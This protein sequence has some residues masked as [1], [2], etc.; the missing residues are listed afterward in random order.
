V[1]LAAEEA[2]PAHGEDVL[3]IDF[4]RGGDAQAAH[5]AAV[6]VE[7]HVGMRGVHRAVGIEHVEMRRHHLQLVGRGL[8]HAVAALFAGRAEMVALDE[9]H[10]QQ[11]A[12]LVVD[13]GRA[14]LDL[15]AGLGL[16][17]AG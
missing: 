6:E 11:G 10:L 12:A 1:D 17:G 5:D 7:Q 8:Q 13:L 9:E 15:H 2:A 4:A 14:V 16:H 3:A